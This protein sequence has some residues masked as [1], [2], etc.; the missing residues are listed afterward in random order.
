MEIRRTE[1]KIP[2]KAIISGEFSCVW[3]FPIIAVPVPL[4]LNLTVYEYD[5]KGTVSFEVGDKQRSVQDL[6]ISESS[7]IKDDELEEIVSL[8]W[9]LADS[10]GF[11]ACFKDKSAKVV[12]KN[13]I[14][15]RMGLG[16]SAAVIV[17]VTKVLFLLSGSGREVDSSVF[18][19]LK[20]IEDRYHQKS[21]G[22]DILTV[23]ENRPLCIKVDNGKIQH[24]RESF[25]LTGMNLLLVS[26][27]REKCTRE[28]L[29]IIQKKIEQ[30]STAVDL[31]SPIERVT[32]KMIEKIDSKVFDGSFQLLFKE[33]QKILSDLN[34]SHPNL[35]KIAEI[36]SRF[37]LG[38]KL[39]G[40]GRGGFALSLIT[41]EQ[42]D[43][44]KNALTTELKKFEFE[45]TCFEL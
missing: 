9:I 16:S 1:F 5:Q 17:G 33:N 11:K 44:V 22:I 39:T 27:K 34:L 6:S 14:P 19:V 40:G 32:L 45:L 29:K 36:F 18:P 26:S 35:D 4:F 21:S 15:L 41:K 7:V 42:L 3:G 10:F 30:G 38:A 8:F 24:L 31:L 13:D 23:L 25:S 20:G 28:S 12:I 37:E 43:S 2:G